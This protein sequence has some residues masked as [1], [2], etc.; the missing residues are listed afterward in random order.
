MRIKKTGYD[1]LYTGKLS[2]GCKQCVKGEKSVF[3]ITGLCPRRCAYCPISDSKKNNDVTYINEW[4]TRD[5]EDIVCE[6]KLCNSKGVGITGGDPLVTIERTINHIKL[7]K[8]TFGKK[9]HVHLYTSL[10]LINEDYMKNLYD[11][12]L[13]E[14]RFHPDFDKQAQWVKL[15]ISRKYDWKIVME[16]PAVPNDIEKIKNLLDKTHMYLDYLNLNELELAD[17]E[18]S[19]IGDEYHAKDDLSYAVMGSEEAA[20]EIMDYANTLGVENVHYCTAT[21]KDKH[22]LTNRIKRRAK[23]VKKSFDKLT[24]EGMLIRGA[25]YFNERKHENITKKDVENSEK[26]RDLLLS[27]GVK[28]K[29]MFFDKDY[30]RVLTEVKIIKKHLDKLKENK[31]HSYIVEE[32]PTKDV[33][34]IEIEEL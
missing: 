6:I 11:A 32:Y 9:F 33:F 21:L 16:I 26:I 23:G 12:G 13:D 14:I 17:N 3:F 24:R 2:S 15:K 31:F 18:F 5:Y 22:Q 1:S 8:G 19:T 10:D 4:E 7:L 20:L 28:E 30:A 27:L 25:I 34:P 29:H